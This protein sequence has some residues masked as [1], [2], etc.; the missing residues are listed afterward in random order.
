MSG[1]ARVATTGSPA[2][3]ERTQRDTG[4]AA[5]HLAC[6]AELAAK[7]AAIAAEE[8]EILFEIA[9]IAG[10][11]L[12]GSDDPSVSANV[13]QESDPPVPDAPEYM[14]QVAL[15]GMLDAHP[16]TV[17]RLELGGDIPAAIRIGNLKRWSRAEVVDWIEN[18]RPP[19]RR[20]HTR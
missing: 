13:T 9:R 10:N 2:Q 6:L 14:S 8:A 4:A 19:R 12:A 18:G 5:A 1:E 17:R 7:R 20:A 3:D 16:R 15:A 11:D